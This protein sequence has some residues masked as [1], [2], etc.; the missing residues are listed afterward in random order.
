MN[1]QMDENCIYAYKDGMFEPRVNLD[2]EAE[3]GQFA[4]CIWS[5]KEPWAAQEKLHVGKGG[6]VVCKRAR[7]LCQVGDTHFFTLNDYTG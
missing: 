6:V 3:N 1:M 5:L 2:E 4:A 7:A